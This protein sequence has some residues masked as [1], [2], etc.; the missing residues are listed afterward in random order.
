VGDGGDVPFLQSIARQGG[1]RFFLTERAAEIPNVLLDEIEVVLR[2]YL[3]ERQFAPRPGPSGAATN[4]EGILSGIDALP[5]LDGYVAS[6][7]RQRAHVLLQTPDE[8]PLLAVWQY[9]LGRSLV[10]TSDMKGQWASDLVRWEQ[11]P[12]LAAQM[13]DWLLP[14]P[15]STRLGLEAR[16][17][18][19]QLSLTAQAHDDA[20]N[21]ATGLQVEDELL[22]ADGSVQH[23]RLRELAP[24][25]YGVPISNAQPGVHQVRLVAMQAAGQPFAAL[26]AGAVVPQG[27][28]Y[29]GR[30]VDYT[31]LKA[32]ARIT[33]GRVNPAP[34]DAY[35]PTTGRAGAPRDLAPLL[36][37]AALALLPIGIAL[38]RLPVRSY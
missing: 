21:P 13:I 23:V 32:L 8:D 34:D 1:G 28:E 20:G 36:L 6:T 33:G 17:F 25:R 15:G 38:R 35:D 18:G 31:L 29:R 3:V 24:G 12:R 30:T 14:A 11:F 26:E 10:W 16:V 4:D 37:W 27:S 19:D 7:A 2:P 9:G 5:Q 22:A